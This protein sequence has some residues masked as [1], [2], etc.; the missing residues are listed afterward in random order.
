[1]G[2]VEMNNEAAETAIG[3]ILKEISDNVE[4]VTIRASEKAALMLKDAAVRRFIGKMFNQ[5][6]HGE[7]ITNPL[8]S[9]TKELKSGKYDG[10]REAEI[11]HIHQAA[12]ELSNLWK[13]E[14]E[15]SAE[16]FKSNLGYLLVQETIINMV[17]DMKA[18]G[19]DIK[20]VLEALS[21]DEK[22]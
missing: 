8:I 9:F 6:K 20:T 17:G 7:M 1:M 21:W 11:N 5:W 4:T 18:G 22:I 2:N 19:S 15:V 13:S 10:L 16:T 12:A 3:N 14:P